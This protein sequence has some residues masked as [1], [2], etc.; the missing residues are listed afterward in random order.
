MYEY[1]Q[2]KQPFLMALHCERVMTGGEASG[3][4]QAYSTRGS[5]PREDRSIQTFNRVTA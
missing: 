5:G 3:K 1:S 2:V 4:E